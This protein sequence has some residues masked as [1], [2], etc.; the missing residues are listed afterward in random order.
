MKRDWRDRGN[1]SIATEYE[2][3]DIPKLAYEILQKFGLTKE[4]I[5]SFDP[6]SFDAVDFDDGVKDGKIPLTHES[7]VQLWFW[8]VK[9]SNPKLEIKTVEVKDEIPCIN[10]YWDKT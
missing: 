6:E 10:G 4:I 1:Y 3:S 8:F 9:L 5:L 7:F 2:Q